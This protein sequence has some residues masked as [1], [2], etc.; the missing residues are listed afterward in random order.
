M[1]PLA[2]IFQNTTSPSRPGT[3]SYCCFP[4]GW[5]T[6][7]TGTTRPTRASAF[8]STSIWSQMSRAKVCASK[9]PPGMRRP[10]TVQNKG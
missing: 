1:R 8:P 2:V 7:W 5:S 6:V 9:F 10:G 4:A 3:G